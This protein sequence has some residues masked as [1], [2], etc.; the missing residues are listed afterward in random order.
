MNIFDIKDAISKIICLENKCEDI[1][2]P[3]ELITTINTI[4]NY[5]IIYK[6]LCIVYKCKED[7]VF[8]SAFC[9]FKADKFN[10]EKPIAIFCSDIHLSLMPPVYR[11]NEPDWVAAMQKPLDELNGLA[12]KW[13]PRSA[14]PN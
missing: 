13:N 4:S 14:I 1:E 7:K 8:S 9:F 12:T 5:T 3:K 11:M 6:D 10:T 2:I